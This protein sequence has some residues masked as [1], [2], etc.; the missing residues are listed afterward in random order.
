MGLRHPRPP[1]WVRRRCRRDRAG[2]CSARNLGALV[3][4][5]LPRLL[6]PPSSECPARR[7]GSARG[8]PLL[9]G[10]SLVATP[11]PRTGG[12]RSG[13]GGSHLHCGAALPVLGRHLHV[14]VSRGCRRRRHLRLVYVTRRL[15]RLSKLAA[16]LRELPASFP[17]ESGEQ[18]REQ[19]WV[20]G[21]T[22]LRSRR[23]RRRRRRRRWNV[24]RHLRGMPGGPRASALGSRGA[25]TGVRGYHL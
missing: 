12:G 23:R 14:I 8:R 1:G 10:A 11:V 5:T 22:S 9:E 21:P 19:L 25:A 24:R 3:L 13:G 6:V 17:G 4:V 20:D 2:P 16:S 18:V 15:R 7:R